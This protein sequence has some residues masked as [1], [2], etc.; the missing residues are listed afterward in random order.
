M[1][2]FVPGSYGFLETQLDEKLSYNLV[3][4]VVAVLEKYFCVLYHYSC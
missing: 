2:I 1:D 3:S 4:F